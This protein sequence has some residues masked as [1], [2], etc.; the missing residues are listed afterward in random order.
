MTEYREKVPS[1]HNRPK[2]SPPWWKRK[3]P[4]GNMPVPAFLPPSH[5]FWCP[6]ER[7]RHSPQAA[8]KEQTR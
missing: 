8:M 7:Y 2:S 3:V 5:G 6:A 1:T 4:S